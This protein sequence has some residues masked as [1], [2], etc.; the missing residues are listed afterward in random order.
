[1]LYC[2]NCKISL[3]GNYKRCPL[4][5]GE[6]TGKA[7]EYGN[8][9]PTIRPSDAAEHRLLNFLAFC[10]VAGTAVCTAVNLALPASG[11]W[12]QFVIGGVCCF[13][14]CFLLVLKKRKNLPKTILWQV[15]ILS[16]MAY[17]WD[18]FT[19]HQ[20]WALNY[21]FPI[22]C[23]G[24]MVAMFV[25]G[26]VRKLNIQDYILYLVIDCIFGILPLT[27][28]LTGKLSVILPSAICFAAAVIF[29]AE[30]LL[31]EGKSLLAEIQRRFHL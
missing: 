11:W 24:A 5:K 21:V 1:M 28:L 22:L 23:T 29:L 10:S 4:C 16:L 30:L 6:L 25:I 19:G 17:L 18:W 26:K 20:G 12:F 7:E 3:P 8:A 31:F 9:F 2:K 15:G 27:L 14:I 13:W